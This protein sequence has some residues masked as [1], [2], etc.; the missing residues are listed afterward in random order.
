MF[1]LVAQTPWPKYDAD[2][3]KSDQVMMAVQVNGKRRAEFLP[4]LRRMRTA[5]LWESVA[6]QQDGSHPRVGW[7]DTKLG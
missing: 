3:V 2:L 1:S 5:R 6:L 4:A 7:Q